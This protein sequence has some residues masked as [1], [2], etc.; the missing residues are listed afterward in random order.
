MDGKGF[1]IT[2]ARFL[3][4][5]VKLFRVVA[6]RV[7]RKQKPGQFVILRIHEQ[8]ERIP[9]T[10]AESNPADGT[11]TL[12]VQG[13]GKTTKLL[14]TLNTGDSIT[15]VVGPLG[16]PSDIRLYGT[17]VVIG[18]GV[19]TAIA[20]PTARA[21]RQ[22]DNHVIAILGARNKDLIILES[23]VRAISSEFFLTTDDGSYGEK[24]LVTDKLRTV[25]ASGRKIDLVLAIGPI[26]MMRAVAET[27]R[28]RG[29][30]T[31]VSLNPIMVDGT[32]MCG[33]CRVLVAGRSQFA[34]VDGPEFDAHQVD[35][36]VLTKRNAMYRE[37]ERQS[38]ER[39]VND[40]KADREQI[41]HRCKL[42]D[43]APR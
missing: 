14:N 42:E 40:P 15:D 26:P 37:F 11:I 8:G 30:R 3:A 33:G 19:G 10:I 9:I 32:G 24:G 27:T 1:T 22:A 16:H 25:I 31:V 38:L 13:V 7:A 39:F 4:A 2:E 18:G 36:D 29:I 28:S 5:D 21:L 6:P 34:C 20:Y 43:I 12:I 35:F 23:E 41:P 17:V